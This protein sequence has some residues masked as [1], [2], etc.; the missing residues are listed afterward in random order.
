MLWKDAPL[1]PIIYGVSPAGPRGNPR[2]HQCPREDDHDRGEPNATHIDESA[3]QQHQRPHDQRCFVEP[4]DYW[5][6]NSQRDTRRMFRF[7]PRTR[8]DVGLHSGW[9][10]TSRSG[11]PF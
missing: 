1:V 10:M 5:R 2:W 11:N 8:E 4:A 9:T 7:L 6:V 3:Y